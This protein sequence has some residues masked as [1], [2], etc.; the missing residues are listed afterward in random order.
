MSGCIPFTFNWW[1]HL[2]VLVCEHPCKAES[3]WG[4]ETY[5]PLRVITSPPLLKLMAFL[6]QSTLLSRSVS[7]HSTPRI[8]SIP[9]NSSMTVNLSVPIV[10]ISPMY[11]LW[12]PLATISKADPKLPSWSNVKYQGYYQLFGNEVMAFFQKNKKL[13]LAPLSMSNSMH[14]PSN[15]PSTF[16]VFGLAIS[17]K[18]RHP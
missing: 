7:R 2:C 9:P 11:L 8:G 12:K 15:C 10:T 13:W 16:M 18:L 17:W 14:T 4:S 5:Y 3:C 1:L 6:F